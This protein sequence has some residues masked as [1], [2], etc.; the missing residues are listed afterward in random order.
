MRIGLS[1]YACSWIAQAGVRILHV[2]TPQ[3]HQRLSLVRRDAIRILLAW[4]RQVTPA[5]KQ[6]QNAVKPA[7]FELA[8]RKLGELAKRFHTV[9]LF[10]PDTEKPEKADI[11]FPS[12]IPAD[13]PDIT[14]ARLLTVARRCEVSLERAAAETDND[15]FKARIPIQ[16]I[17]T[18]LVEDGR[19]AA[20]DAFGPMAQLN[21]HELVCQLPREIKREWEEL[22][23]VA[24]ALQRAP[25]N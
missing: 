20:E 21:D 25:K 24:N 9:H 13:W 3:E 23:L 1:E 19:H 8:R 4:Y 12:A 10:Q 22:G 2:G 15:P 6:L 17:V 7:E 18:I 11:D 16:D 14:K 5:A